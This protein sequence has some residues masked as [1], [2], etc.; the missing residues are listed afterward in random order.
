MPKV[1]KIAGLVLKNDEGCYLLV[2]EQ[3]EPVHG[4]WNL[5][6]GHVDEGETIQEAAIRET[7]EETGLETELIDNEPVTVTH[8]TNVNHEYYA[9]LGRVTGGSLEIDSEEL[10]D[11]QWLS[12]E[13]IKQLASEDKMRDPLTIKT[14]LTIEDNEN[15]GH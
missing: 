2:Q 9:F 11:A 8:I 4:L 5:P 3:R 13:H 7:R 6:G 1:A 10:L 14:I 12:T 15:S